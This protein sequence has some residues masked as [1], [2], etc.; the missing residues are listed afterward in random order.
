M[1][2]DILAMIMAILV[3]IPGSMVA[4]P[5]P[6]TVPPVVESPAQ[7]DFRG[8][9]VTTVIN[10]DFP[11]VPGLSNEE[12]RQEIRYIVEHSRSI[13]L[14]AIILQVRPAG[15]AFYP[16]QI[17]P[18]SRYLSG[19]EGVAPADGFDPLAYWL[20]RTQMA[21]IELHAWI[22]PYRVTHSTANI[23]DVNLL[24]YN[25][26]AR[27]RPH[28]VRR[29]PVN[30]ALYLDPGIPE[31]QQLIIDGV[32]ELLINYPTLAGIHF[33]DYFY[34]H[35][36]F[37][38]AETF[39][40]Y[41]A[42]FSS[43]HEWRVNNVNNLIQG[44]RR[45]ID[46]INPN[47]RFGISPTGIWANEGSHPLGSA[48]RGFQHYFDI[49]ADSIRWIQEGWIDYIIPQIYW[50]IG[51]DI[52]DYAILLRWWEDVVRGTNVGL[53]IGHA[54]YREALGHANFSGE[55]LR[56]LQMNEGSDVVSG[57]VF[58]RWTH[59]RGAIGDMVR[60]W[61][62]V[63]PIST[64][65]SP[66]VIM[67]E[68]SVN[69]PPQDINV[70]LAAAG[71]NLWGTSIP[72]L[73]LYL[74]GELITGR[75]PE[76]FFSL[77]A[78]LE[79]GMNVFE[80][81]QSDGSL[82]VRTINKTAPAP[83]TDDGTAPPPPPP[84]PPV[85]EFD[86]DQ[87]FY[88][89]VTTEPAWLFP[90]ATATGGSNQ[91]IERG[92]TDRIVA[93]N[94]NWL[95]MSNGGWINADSVIIILASDL[96]ENLLGTGVFVESEPHEKVIVWHLEDNFAPAARSEF[97]DGNVVVYFGMQTEAP[98]MP[99]LP[100]DSIVASITSGVN[101][102]NI[103]YAIFTPKNGIRINGHDLSV[104][105]DGL[106]LT[107]TSPRQL[108]FDWRTPL[109]GFT[110]VID[111]GHGGNDVGAIGAMGGA[112]AE[113]HIVLDNSLLLAER[114]RTLG[115]GV[116]VL[117]EDND[118]F[119][120]VGERVLAS[121]AIRPD[122]FISMHANSVA[123]TTDATNIRGFT[124]WYRNEI[125][126][127][128]ALTILNG[129]HYVN[130]TTNRFFQANQANFYVCRPSWTPSVLLEAGFMSNIHDF[131]WLIDPDN[132]EFMADETVAAIVRYFAITT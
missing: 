130:P 117:R 132:Q 52:A 112:L 47:V 62:A 92:M 5:E 114:L 78:E 49:S 7:T 89:T 34:P 100:Q 81:T 79:T 64:A 29:H 90:N 15:D 98:P 18:W 129:L 122:M 67:D 11:S 68:L 12:I 58:F 77:Y 28:L 51:F 116:V 14:N 31:A 33:D 104:S 20:E 57:S 61:Y 82:V 113:K 123:E 120:T 63:R 66:S 43:L 17:F 55:M 60:N 108:N 41:G 35:R 21:G 13:G 22:N 56:Q 59:L 76:G 105:D 85:W 103:A 111:P 115:A 125:S 53:H 69:M 39:A 96:R 83:V 30:S 131:A 91:F 6:G 44:I 9:W 118:T 32:R 101:S 19:T 84:P 119:L 97:V 16:S 87:I 46:E 54:A 2:N 4:M 124:V 75:T 74:N 73:P 109:A 26:P 65:R 36:N 99:V 70:N 50:Y 72:D 71:Y 128:A 121:R 93:S 88:A 45:T 10:L 95:R 25:N 86:E 110:F 40:R 1:I 3:S 106:Q 80:F 102:E 27:L 126:Q 42:G 23:T 48:T 107:I 37:D 24:S 8:V 38:D 94:G 127:P